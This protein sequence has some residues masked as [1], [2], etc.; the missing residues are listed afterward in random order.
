MPKTTPNEQRVASALGIVSEAARLQ[1]GLRDVE[2]VIAHLAV[3]AGD[4]EVALEVAETVREIGDGLMVLAL[5]AADH[6]L[7]GP[8]WRRALSGGGVDL[9]AV[10]VVPDAPTGTALIAVAA[11]GENHIVVAPGANRKLSADGL[12][13]P[14]VDALLCQL[15]VPVETVASAAAGF[16]GFFSINLAPAKHVDVAVLQR[17]DLIVVNEVEAAWYGDSLVAA[18]GMIATTVGAAGAT[19]RSGSSPRPSSWSAA[20]NTSR[21]TARR[22]TSPCSRTWCW[23]TSSSRPT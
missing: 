23:A 21:R 1:R 12:Q 10:R 13:V 8:C 11:S 4:G 17:A 2:P 18:G 14:A 19:I 6:L 9:S 16:D 20:A 15:E 5:L 7:E 22:T 3:A